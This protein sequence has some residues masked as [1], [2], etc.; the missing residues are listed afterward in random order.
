[1]GYCTQINKPDDLIDTLVVCNNVIRNVDI[2]MKN[3]AE[4]PDYDLHQFFKEIVDRT[5]D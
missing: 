1:M 3:K 2:K 4:F 5:T